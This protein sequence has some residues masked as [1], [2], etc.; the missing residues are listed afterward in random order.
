MSRVR[1]AT[2]QKHQEASR[3][4]ETLISFDEIGNKRHGVGMQL[5]KFD[6]KVSALKAE[7]SG[8]RTLL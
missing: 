3:E 2:G 5:S 1:K 4:N 8:V 7:H 6:Q